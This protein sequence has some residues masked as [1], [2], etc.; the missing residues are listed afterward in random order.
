MSKFHGTKILPCEIP[1]IIN[2]N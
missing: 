2:S 1:V